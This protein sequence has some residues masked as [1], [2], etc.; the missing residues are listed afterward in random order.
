MSVIPEAPARRA[1]LE[2]H[3]MTPV[4]ANTAN[5]EN[6]IKFEYWVEV[7]L[8]CRGVSCPAVLYTAKNADQFLL[9]LNWFKDNHALWDIANDTIDINGHIFQ[10]EDDNHKYYAES[11]WQRKAKQTL[12]EATEGERSVEDRAILI[13][14]AYFPPVYEKGL[15]GQRYEKPYEPLK[16]PRIRCTIGDDDA[17]A[18]KFKCVIDPNIK[19]SLIPDDLA[20]DYELRIEDT[21]EMYLASQSKDYLMPIE[22]WCVVPLCY[23]GHTCELSMYL[24]PLLTYIVLGLCLLYTSDAADE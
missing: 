4:Y 1:G 23:K 19:M 2:L 7:P 17:D 14:D 22:A 11:S 16:A 6:Q 13:P 5:K 15:D 12:K 10:V 9:G 24:V 18:E 8:Y 20:R 3:P 21:R